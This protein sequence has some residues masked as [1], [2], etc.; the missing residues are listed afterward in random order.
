M[1]PIEKKL[2]SF[3]SNTDSMPKSTLLLNL[4]KQ[5]VFDDMKSEALLELKKML[6]NENAWKETTNAENPEKDKTY[7][8]TLE[9][10]N[11]M[12]KYEL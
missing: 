11:L 7:K 2:I 3:E 1:S 12:K 4:I 6:Q 10:I 5:G 8:R 9:I